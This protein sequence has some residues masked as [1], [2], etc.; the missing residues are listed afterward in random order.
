MKERTIQDYSIHPLNLETSSGRGMAIYTH[1]SIDKSV[2]EIKPGF[3]EA[4]LIE[5]K[6]RG[7]DKLL[8]GSFYRRP[9]PTI[10]SDVNNENL[11]TA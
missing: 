3:D 11:N 4:C 7:G 8:F 6:L 10:T 9:T 5:V 2:V 1:N